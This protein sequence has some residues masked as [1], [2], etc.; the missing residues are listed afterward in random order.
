MEAGPH[1]HTPD[2][3]GPSLLLFQAGEIE[4]FIS[5]YRSA[6]TAEILSIG[7]LIL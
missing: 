1:T 4:T 7:T 6:G 3:L 2:E 5:C